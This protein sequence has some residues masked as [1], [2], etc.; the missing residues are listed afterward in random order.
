MDELFLGV[1]DYQEAK[2]HEIKLKSQGIYLIL[3]K[4]DETCGTGSC[5]VRLEVWA[6]PKDETFLRNY[7]KSDFEKHAKGHIPNYDHLSEVYDPSA[8]EVICQACGAKFNPK[9]NEC[10]DCGLV[11]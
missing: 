5:R 6:N 9:S 10:P 1:M 8:S 3:K 7:F 4:N 2:N 11:Y